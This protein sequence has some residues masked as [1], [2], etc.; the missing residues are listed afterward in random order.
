MIVDEEVYL[1]HFGVRGMKWGVRKQRRKEAYQRLETH[2]HK[3]GK[4]T[5]WERAGAIGGGYA[6][7]QVGAIAVMKATGNLQVANLASL[8]MAIAGGLW[9]RKKQMKSGMG[10]TPVSS[11]KTNRKAPQL[12]EDEIYRRT[13]EFIKKN[14][15]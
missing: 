8:P 15:T 1:E 3:Q 11:I 5:G 12:S 4:L 13:A 10:R 2:R 9:I 14:K 7:G 6:I